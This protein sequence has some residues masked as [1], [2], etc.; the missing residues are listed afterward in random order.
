M[1]Q[2]IYDYCHIGNSLYF[3]IPLKSF[4]LV[5]LLGNCGPFILA[6]LLSDHIEREALHSLARTN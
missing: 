6:P 4:W 5:T 3:C 1:D 2:V